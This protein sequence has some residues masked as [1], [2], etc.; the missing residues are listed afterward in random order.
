MIHPHLW[1]PRNCHGTLKSSWAIFMEYMLFLFEC[2][3]R[4]S[5]SIPGCSN[6]IL[7][8]RFIE[9]FNIYPDASVPGLGRSHRK[10]K[11]YVCL[12]NFQIVNAKTDLMTLFFSVYPIFLTH[13]PLTPPPLVFSTLPLLPSSRSRQCSPPTTALISV[14][15]CIP[16]QAA[17][18]TY[19]L[20]AWEYRDRY[21]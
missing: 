1:K 14:L 5:N 16:R 21:Q 7:P 8:V 18:V 9:W 19:L 6:E 4:K 2:I 20:L 15:F 10:T 13:L 11:C 3:W 17:C 12:C